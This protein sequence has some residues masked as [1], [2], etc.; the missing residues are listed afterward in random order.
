MKLNFHRLTGNK[1][2]KKILVIPDVHGRLFWKEP[3]AKL[4]N[5]VDRIVFL[6]D[7]LDPYYHL[8]KDIADDIFQNLQEIVQLKRENPEKVVLLKGN[9]DQH[10][11]STIFKKWA[12]GTRMDEENWEEYHEFFQKNNKLFQLAHLEV[13]KGTTYVFTHAGI[14]QYWLHKVNTELW[15]LPEKKVS[16]KDPEIIRK[17]NQLDDEGEGQKLLSVIG[18]NRAWFGEETGSILWAD[19][20]EHDTSKAP[21]DYGLNQVFQVFG[22]TRLKDAFEKI[23]RENLAMIDSR[24]C[25]MIDESR[26]EK[27]LSLRKYLPEEE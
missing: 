26:K 17:I 15:K 14:T 24:Q 10:Y 9:H 21:R 27:I 12:G 22:H 2:P 7:Y 4:L 6:G 18:K 19:I 11:C 1:T 5:E 3:V 23:S 13:V 20:D 16:L 8:E 25:F